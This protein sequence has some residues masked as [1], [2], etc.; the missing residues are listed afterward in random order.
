MTFVD[1][2]ANSTTLLQAR[3]VSL[4]YARPGA[5]EERVV[6][7]L[8]L[9]VRRGEF[10]ALVGPSGAGKTTIMKL[11]CGLIRP[12]GGAI[13]YDGMSLAEYRRAHVFSYIFQNPVL[14]P[15]L[16]VIENAMFPLEVLPAGHARNP[17]AREN[18]LELLEIVGLADAVH[19]YPKELSGGMQQRLAVVTALSVQPAVLFLDEPFG[20]LDTS[21]R[22][23]LQALLIRLLRDRPNPR[24]SIL[25]T[26]DLQEAFVLA[27]RVLVV[28]GKP[29]G[30][31]TL[32][33]RAVDGPPERHP[34]HAY[35]D[36]V[37]RQVREVLDLIDRNQPKEL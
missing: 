12:T 24:T 21:S 20:A 8:D 18:V 34:D 7:D 26:H 1:R 13:S 3:G 17:A 2:L 19:K 25:V 27:D 5:T 16:T 15:W 37:T 28:T 6:T 30:P 33:V 36:R 11:L 32:H 35:G 9:D 10:V 29:I 4:S 14:L 22:R 23:R 31:A